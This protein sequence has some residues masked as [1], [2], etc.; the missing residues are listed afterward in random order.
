MGV[1]CKTDETRTQGFGGEAWGNE[2]LGRPRR[3]E[4][5]RTEINLTE[6]GGN[7]VGWIA[8][9]HDWKKLAGCYEHGT[10]HSDSIK[11]GE[12]LGWLRNYWLQNQS[13]TRRS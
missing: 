4:E 11:Q 7:G 12:F 8:L 3:N 6:I 1:A 13:S 5:D 2:P 10:E 9:A